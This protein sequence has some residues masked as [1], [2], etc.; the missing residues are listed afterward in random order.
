MEVAI[1]RSFI[2]DLKTAPKQI[3]LAADKAIKKLIEASSLQACGLDYTKMEGQKKGEN[4]YRI[5][6]GDWRMGIEYVHPKVIVI[7]I[8]ARG[9]IYKH[10][11]PGK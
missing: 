3:Q 9:T 10:F 8:L 1:A 4:Y 2:K 7:R 11:P 6:V 5:R